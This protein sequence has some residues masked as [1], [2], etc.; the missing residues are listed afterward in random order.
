[1]AKIPAVNVTS[2]VGRLVMGSLYDPKTTDAEGKPLVVKNGPN[3]G[4]ARVDYFFALA[5]PKGA[6]RHW[7]ETEWGAKIWA[8]GHAAFPQQAQSPVFA[9]K[10]DDGDSQIPNRKGRKPCE[11][12]GWP[13]HWVLKFGGGFAPKVYKAENGAYVQLTEPGALKLGYYAQVAFRVSG[14]SS[15]SQPGIYLNHDLVCF[16]AYGSEISFGPDVN[17]V[18][19]GAAPLPAGASLTPPAAAIPLPSAPGGAPSLPPPPAPGA[20]G[21]I[22]AAPSAAPA[23]PASPAP[24]AVP[25][26]PNLNFAAL[27]A[28]A[29]P[30]APAVPVRTMTA[31]AAGATYEQFQAQGWTDEMM[32]AQGFMTM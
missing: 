13:G 28:P 27:A 10:I 11:N 25:V 18:G 30:A 24:T 23:L 4:Q 16:S 5:I 6:E 9:W 32:I 31:L 8:A 7:A 12:E 22:L 3:S 1:M 21:G 20:A 17:S 14:N 15:D 29:A 26:V 19:F 2:P